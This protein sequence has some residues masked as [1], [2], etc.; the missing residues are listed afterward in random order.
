MKVRIS[1]T[2]VARTFPDLLDRI[3]NRGE[4]FIIERGGKP[5]CTMSPVKPPRCTG[6]DLAALLRSLPKPDA[7]FED[8]ALSAISASELLHGIYR[9]KTPAQRNRREA[10]VGN[11]LG[12]LPVLPLWHSAI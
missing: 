12:R 7:A 6:A 4:E 9:A 11:L 8:F 5:V 1:A 3:R 2:Q 10:F